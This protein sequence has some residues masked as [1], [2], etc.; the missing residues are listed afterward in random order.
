MMTTL[1]GLDVSHH[2][3]TI[4]CMILGRDGPAFTLHD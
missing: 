1:T 3:G 4:D 2:S